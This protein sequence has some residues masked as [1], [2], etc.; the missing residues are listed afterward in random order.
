MAGGREVDRIVGV[1]P[2]QAIRAR[3]ERVLAGSGG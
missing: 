1:L 3:L 2:K